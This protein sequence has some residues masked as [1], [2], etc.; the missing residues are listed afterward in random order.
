M[1]ESK[2]GVALTKLACV[3]CNKKLDGD[4]LMN[5]RLTKSMAEKVE[6]MHG[7]V[8]GFADKPCPECLE[9]IGEGI[10]IIEVNEQLTDDYENPYR[11]GRQW[12]VTK[13]FM[14]HVVNDEDML[15]ATLK[16]QAC[17][18]PMQAC[19]ELGLPNQEK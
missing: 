5:T 1:S 17:F 16:K 3:V 14:E 11:T 13:D 19:R 7:Q 2:L 4:I 6:A 12:G 15:K 9:T 10:W 18:M 8:T